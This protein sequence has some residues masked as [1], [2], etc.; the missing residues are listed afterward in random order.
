MSDDIQ[1]EAMEVDVLI[2]G[3]G[4]AGLSAAIRL[5]QIIQDNPDAFPEPPQIALVEKG[6]EIGAHVLSGAVL[7]PTALD[8]LLPGW[9]DEAPIGYKVRLEEFA[10]MTATKSMPGPIPPQMVA[11]GSYVVSAARM[12]RWMA[13]KAEALDIMIFP[14]F[15]ATDVIWDGDQVL[16]FGDFNG[17]WRQPD[18]VK[19]K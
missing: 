7:K 3:G 4:A 14:G 8:E 5:G 10:A 9:Q 11:K 6:S 13:T 2:V 15:P 12:A 17:S 1:R 16:E 19:L 18:G